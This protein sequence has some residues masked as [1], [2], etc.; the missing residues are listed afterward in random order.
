M[1]TSTACMSGGTMDNKKAP[2][3]KTS[4]FYYVTEEGFEPSTA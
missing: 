1:K 3:I 4:A 2:A